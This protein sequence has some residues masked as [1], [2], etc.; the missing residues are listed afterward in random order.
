[1][2]P[3]RTSSK[4]AAKRKNA[5]KG[6]RAAPKARARRSSSSWR[7]RLP[8]IEQRHLDLAGLALVAAGVFLAFPLYLRW[9]G[10]AA[11]QPVVDGLTWALGTVAYAIP[12]ALVAAGALIVHEPRAP[13]RP[14]VPGGRDLPARLGPAPV[15]RG[16]RARPRERRRRR[17][18]APRRGGERVLGRRGEHHRDLPGRRRDAAA[19]RRVGRGRAERDAHRASRETTRGLRRE[20]RRDEA[21]DWP[22]APPDESPFFGPPEPAGEEPVVRPRTSGA[23]LD[24]ALRYPDLFGSPAEIAI[25]APPRPEP[26]PEP[27]DEEPAADPVPELDD[28]ARAAARGPGRRAERPRREAGGREQL[29]LELPVADQEFALPE[30]RILKR[31]TAEQ[32]RPDTAGQE[33]TAG[34]AHRGA[35]PLR[36]PGARSSAR[37]PA[38]TS[39]ATSCGSRRASRW[40]RSRSSRTTSPT[41][42]PRPTSASSRRS[43]ASSAVGVE[44]PNRNRRIVHLGDVSA[45]RRTDSSPLTVWLGKD[46]SGQGD[47]RRPR[48]DAAPARRRHDGRGQVGLHQRD[49]VARSCCARRRDDV[50]LV[51]VDPK[52][53]ELNHYEAIPHLLTP[54]ITSPRMAANAL[55]NLV[56]RDGVALRRDV[57]EAHALARRAQ[58]RARQGGRQ[59]PLPYILCVIDELADLMM[60]A[61]GR[62]RGLDHPPRAEG[63]RGRHPPRARDA[64]PAGRR[65]HRA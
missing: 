61:P 59:A 9:D 51:L 24:G 49:A 33:Q 64:A 40:R 46:V 44:V 54:V 52:Q 31:S 10:G 43:P 26:E 15:R 50:R 37:S 25:T 48:Q 2:P 58:Q 63:P 8:V 16:R 38:R 19:H 34:A 60:V 5:A 7:P 30:P 35:R 3:A 21:D 42:S 41:R 57:G 27:L 12:V 32:A 4:P 18:G 11:G 65:H 45:T 23:T 13:G 1:M 39:R 28:P 62:R 22:E 6:G 14:P 55:Q 17:P 29:D 47:R 56:A 36:R 53:V 20:R